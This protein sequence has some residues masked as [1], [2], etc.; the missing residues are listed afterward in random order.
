MYSVFPYIVSDYKSAQAR[1]SQHKAQDLQKAFA[2]DKDVFHKII[3]ET[4]QNSYL[5]KSLLNFIG[6]IITHGQT[7]G[8]ELVQKVD[9]LYKEPITLTTEELNFFD[10]VN[11]KVSDDTTL[12]PE[13][14]RIMTKHMNSQNS[15][16]LTKLDERSKTLEKTIILNMLNDA[17]RKNQQIHNPKFKELK[18]SNSTWSYAAD[19]FVGYHTL[20]VNS[21][22][23][24]VNPKS[25]HLLG[26]LA[27]GVTFAI[28]DSLKTHY[29]N[30][31]KENELY[32]CYSQASL[33][34]L[35]TFTAHNFANTLTETV[36]EF[37]FERFVDDNYTQIDTN[38][39]NDGQRDLRKQISTDVFGFFKQV[40][41]DG[42]SYEPS[43]SK[44]FISQYKDFLCQQG[45]KDECAVFDDIDLRNV[46]AAA[47]PLYV[48]K[49]KLNELFAPKYQGLNQ[50]ISGASTLVY[51]VELGDKIAAVKI[52]DSDIACYDKDGQKLIP[53]KSYLQDNGEKTYAT[54]NLDSDQKITSLT[55]PRQAEL[56]QLEKANP[57]L[58]NYRFEISL[59]DKKDVDQVVM[60]SD[61]AIRKGKSLPEQI[62]T[63]EKKNFSELAS[64][65]P[66]NSDSHDYDD[67]TVIVLKKAS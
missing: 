47:A 1:M 6:E 55:F 61:G 24:K 20:G 43:S 57:K 34:Y 22:A 11:A 59:Y 62:N 39:L 26:V 64:A 18:L 36:A 21:D 65:I 52:S 54:I 23:F 46:L 16:K 50:D 28:P 49:D 37:P 53:Q 60:V 10:K 5:E 30:L 58:K 8:E 40:H 4:F 33:D 48:I 13:E 38:K 67:K 12:S 25:K 15:K 2:E 63:D 31:N 19:S 51:A 56:T 42:F 17:L 7:T 41:R 3:S 45:R 14:S 32:D 35:K 27:D 9:A 29:K 66:T 44:D